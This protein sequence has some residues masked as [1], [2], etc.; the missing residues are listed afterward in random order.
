MVNDGVGKGYSLWIMPAK[1]LYQKLKEKITELGS[2]YNTPIFE[3]HITL[4]GN[5]QADLETAI[6]NTSVLA[7]NMAQVHATLSAL[8]NSESYFKCVYI[9]VRKTDPLM[10]YNLIARK[11]F[12]T[13]QQGTYEPHISLIYGLIDA[14]NRAEILKGM[15]IDTTSKFL[16]DT[17]CLYSTTGP[18][19]EWSEYAR[20]NLKPSAL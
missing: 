12:N 8:G 9:E 14:A 7:G 15:E 17:L 2:I 4:L 13:Q 16:F 10:R 6:A 19:G 1:P 11:I 3:P 5:I 18:V 20:F